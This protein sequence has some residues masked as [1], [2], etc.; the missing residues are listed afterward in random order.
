MVLDVLYG[1]GVEIE[2]SGQDF[3]AHKTGFTQKS[4]L[5]ALNRSGFSET[6]SMVGNLTIEVLAFKGVPDKFACKLFGLP[7]N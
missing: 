1:Y 6:F 4:L 3:F 2:Q 5:A 7:D